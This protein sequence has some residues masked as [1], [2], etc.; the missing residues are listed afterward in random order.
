MTLKIGLVTDDIDDGNA[1]LATYSRGLAAGLEFFSDD[2]DVTL[3]HRLDHPFYAGRK[4]L[5]VPGL[6]KGR[7]ATKGIGNKIIRKQLMM[8]W[9]L[10]S[11]QFDVVHDTYH[12]APFL[13][14]S[15][16]ARVV[17]I[18]DLVPL[19]M[20]ETCACSVQSHVTHRTLVRWV[21]KRA[22]HIITDSDCTRRDVI[23]HYR[24]PPDRVTTVYLAAGNA[25][26][27]VEDTEQLLAVREKFD[28]PDEF[29]LY[30]G[31]LEPRKNLVRL[32]GAYK[33]ALPS[34]GGIPL[35]LGGG[36][37]WKYDEIL[38]AAKD[39]S[40]E[41]R[42]RLL[43]RVPDDD[44][45]ALYNLATVFVFPSLYEGFGL[46]VL[47]A[48]ACGTPVITSRTSS[49]PEVAGAAG[50]LVD[51]LDEDEIARAMVDVVSQECLRSTLSREGLAQAA[52]FSWQRCAQET[53]EVYR[54]VVG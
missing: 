3:I 25:F 29:I 31:T 26:R 54:N 6:G 35:I 8:P 7:T 34:L 10:R 40:L 43:G 37:G 28:L 52:K 12:Y 13:S 42:V 17:T 20:P 47:E 2:L 32:I 53:L 24:V 51:P 38:R 44:L 4:N 1:G 48:M 18:H 46:P 5:A 27:P 41:G 21:A 50:L 22:G 15:S 16:Y 11:R 49:L 33:R 14:P 45:P 9:A 36:L 39:P 30:V 23:E 19:V